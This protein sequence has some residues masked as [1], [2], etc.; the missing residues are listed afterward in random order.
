[1]SETVILQR[2]LEPIFPDSCVVCQGKGNVERV[3][4]K[5]EAV[6]GYGYVKWILGKSGRCEVPA[7]SGC[8]KKLRRRSF[9]RNVGVLI[10]FTSLPIVWLAM[11]VNGIQMPFEF[12][13][14]NL[15]I[16]AVIFALPIF[17]VEELCPAAFE[18]REGEN[19][20]T[21]DFKDADYA[22]E[23]AKLNKTK[24]GINEGYLAELGKDIAGVGK[25]I[26]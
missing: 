12:N 9:W 3:S 14:L 11:R 18:F 7:H 22:E 5:G 13:K 17:M 25:R 21:F 16:A 26:K 23:F 10:F 15:C 24:T 8:A 20:V 6:G 19:I 2:D 1:M 4:V